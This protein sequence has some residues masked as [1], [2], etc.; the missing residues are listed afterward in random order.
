MSHFRLCCCYWRFSTTGLPFPCT[1]RLEVT[2]LKHKCLSGDAIVT[3]RCCTYHHRSFCSWLGS[4]YQTMCASSLSR[5]LWHFLLS[6]DFLMK[7]IKLD[8][9][10]GQRIVPDNSSTYNYPLLPLHLFDLE[11]G[12]HYH[13]FGAQRKCFCYTF[14]PRTS[15]PSLAVL[16]LH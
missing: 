5:I 1:H 8:Y 9:H 15:S 11:I 6:T 7:S 10:D 3:C 12:H 2:S 16:Q 13:Y 14:I 4:S